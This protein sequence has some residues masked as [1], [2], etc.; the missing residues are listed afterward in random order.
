MAKEL[1][2]L[3]ILQVLLIGILDSAHSSN[4]VFRKGTEVEEIL[5]KV[6]KM[7]RCI[8]CFPTWEN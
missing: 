4:P 7:D 8:D 3:V 2:L 1:K 5:R 6:A